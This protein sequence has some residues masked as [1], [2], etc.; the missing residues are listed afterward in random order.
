MQVQEQLGLGSSSL[1][2]LLRLLSSHQKQ[3]KAA[4]QSSTLCHKEAKAS[5]LC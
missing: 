4:F 5:R 1:V 2:L 3:L